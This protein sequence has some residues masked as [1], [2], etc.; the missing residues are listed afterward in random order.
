[1]KDKPETIPQHFIR[2]RIYRDRERNH[3]LGDSG[4]P[5]SNFEERTEHW[6]EEQCQGSQY[7]ICMVCFIS[8]AIRFS[9]VCLKSYYCLGE[10]L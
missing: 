3:V 4:S 1:M 9:C 5:S 6:Q 10:E 2:R 8:T 7:F